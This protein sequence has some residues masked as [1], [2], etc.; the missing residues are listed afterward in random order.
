MTLFSD[1]FTTVQNVIA[2]SSTKRISFCRIPK[3]DVAIPLWL[4]SSK[5]SQPGVVRAARIRQI[6]R[7]A[8]ERYV[9]SPVNNRNSTI[10]G[11]AKEMKL[12]QQKLNAMWHS[13]LQQYSLKQIA[14]LP[15]RMRSN[16]ESTI[17][18]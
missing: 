5:P 12:F 14:S 16:E 3:H 18:N 2:S 8:T 10:R 11:T 13:P 1:C 9:C 17:I 6:N 15:N 4:K 7:F